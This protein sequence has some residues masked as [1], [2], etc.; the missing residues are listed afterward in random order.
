[1][2]GI[3]YR[4]ADAAT[5][6]LFAVDDELHRRIVRD[7]KVAG[8][9]SVFVISTCNR[10]EI[11]GYA[12]HPKEL[13]S[14]LTEQTTGTFGEFLHQGYFL[15]GKEALHHLFRVAA[16][17]DSQIIGDYEIQGQLKQAINAARQE[18]MIGPIMDRTLNF[19]FQAS[20]KI[21]TNTG[22]STG[23]VSV[24]FA[25]IEWLQQ[26]V[27]KRELKALV[28]GTG[29][30]GANVCKNLLHYM[31]NISLTVCNRTP[32]RAAALAKSLEVD[33]I[34]FESLPEQLQ[35]FD[36]I[37]ASTAAQDP[38]VRAAH[39]TTLKE[40]FVVDLSIPANVEKE[41]GQIPGVHFAN[42]DD[43]SV[44][45]EQN[46]ARRHTEVPKAEAII[47]EFEEEFY[48][49]L[50]MYKHTPA[51]RLFKQHLSEWTSQSGCEF[52]NQQ[53][54]Q[55][56]EL[57]ELM[58]DTINDL[59]VNLKHRAEKGCY[60]IEAYQQFLNHPAVGLSAS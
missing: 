18:E 12:N 56:K 51:I 34:S 36:I 32:E 3:S 11:Y 55:S 41:V 52:A 60:V 13:G 33:S 8:F 50:H 47:A 20:K 44:I 29:K 19:V 37:V 24:S 35:D 58:H 2:A 4:Q 7:A 28:I 17:L 25:A 57:Q 43:I 42:V 27:G 38:I 45:L 40:R 23:T 21:R 9:K 59:V 53:G 16:G 26:K 49:W 46:I 48:N 1:M 54:P 31:P 30:F 10:T 39:F 15:Q 5:R 6:G 22:L 14:L